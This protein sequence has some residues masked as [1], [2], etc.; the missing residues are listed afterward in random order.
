[1]RFVGDPLPAPAKCA[2]NPLI[3]R[4]VHPSTREPELRIIAEKL[5]SLAGHGSEESAHVLRWLA[6]SVDNICNKEYSRCQLQQR[7][8]VKGSAT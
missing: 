8:P 4:N 1:M 2:T 6:E 3:D 5:R 7:S